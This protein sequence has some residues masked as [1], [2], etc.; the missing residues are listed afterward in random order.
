[1]RA[2][3]SMVAACGGGTRGPVAGE[4]DVQ[5]GAQLR[6][7]LLPERAVVRHLRAARAPRRCPGP[8]MA[9]RRRTNAAPRNIPEQGDLKHGTCTALS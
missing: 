1:M 8:A 2:L 9:Q 7:P 6:R 4:Q 3:R 5:G